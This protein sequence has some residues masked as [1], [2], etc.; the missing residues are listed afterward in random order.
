M[1]TEARGV[2]KPGGRL[3]I[4]FIDRESL[5]GQDYLAHQAENVFYRE[6][7]FYS[8]E[9]VEQLLLKTGFSI[10]AWAQT[11]ALPLPETGEIE[12]LHA[13]YGRCAFVVVTATSGS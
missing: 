3:V 13:G 6:A 12:A 10:G 1:L 9:V 2:L 5:L 7:T 8:A 4:G 11:L